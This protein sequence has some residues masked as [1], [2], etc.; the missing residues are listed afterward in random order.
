[1]SYGKSVSL[2]ERDI[3]CPWGIVQGRALQI[4][5]SIDFTPIIKKLL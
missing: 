4:V 2:V 5:D 3:T 1:M